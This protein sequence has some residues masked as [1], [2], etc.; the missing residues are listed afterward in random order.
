[1]ELVR[2]K[3]DVIVTSD[4]PTTAAAQRATATIPIVGGLGG[5][6]VTAGLVASLA[7][8]GGNITGATT[9]SAEVGQKRLELLREIAPKTSLVAVLWTPATG[10]PRISGHTSQ[11]REIES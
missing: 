11:M 2:L 9:I 7:R 1:E 4:T 5:D 3:M 6:P 10:P 8:P